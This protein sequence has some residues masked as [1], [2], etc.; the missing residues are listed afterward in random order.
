MMKAHA[1]QGSAIKYLIS[2]QARVCPCIDNG[3]KEN[4]S[5]FASVPFYAVVSNI[6]KSND[7]RAASGLA[8]EQGEGEGRKY[9]CHL[10]RVS[11]EGPPQID[12]GKPR[13]EDEDEHGRN[14]MCV[15]IS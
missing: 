12:E 4:C 6:F 3:D 5:F 2:I 15:D 11:A 13:K 9:T 7:G 14:E 10:M 8:R 1:T